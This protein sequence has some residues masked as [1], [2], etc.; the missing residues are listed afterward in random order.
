MVNSDAVIYT[1]IINQANLIKKR[2]KTLEKFAQRSEISNDDERVRIV[3]RRIAD[4]TAFIR[5]L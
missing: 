2:I 5:V 4:E 1:V 3:N